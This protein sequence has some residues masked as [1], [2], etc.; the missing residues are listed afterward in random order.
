MEYVLEDII[1]ENQVNLL[2]GGSG[3][4]KSRLL[5]MLR[6]AIELGGKLFGRQTK[7][8]RWGYIAGDRTSSSIHETLSRMGLSMPVF[9]CVDNN[10][11][12]ARVQDVFPLL[13]DALGYRPEILAID[14]FTSFVPKGELNNYAVVAK[15][16]GELQNW[17]DREKVTVVG[18]CHTT[19]TRE[20][21]KLLDP[22]QRIVG[23]VAWASYSEGVI[24]IDKPFE[25]G[26]K[27]PWREISLCSRNHGTKIIHATFDE[28]GWLVER[29]GE[30]E[31]VKESALD[32]VLEEWLVAGAELLNKALERIVIEAGIS[33]ATFYRW[34]KKGKESGRFLEAGRG[35]FVVASLEDGEEELMGVVGTIQ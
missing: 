2:A 31:E 12:G 22:R 11:I 8:V 26:E 25:E 1:A 33:R 15:W 24:V 4:G 19:K 18:C 7:Q 16:L 28:T 21:E 34:L 20:G 27:E 32:M 35:K 13:V 5:F 10:L 17:C 23:S 30:A 29:E 14:G 9:S 3:S 6:A